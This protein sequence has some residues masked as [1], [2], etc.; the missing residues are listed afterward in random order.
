MIEPVLWLLL[1]LVPV[2][3]VS[4][5]TFRR[6]KVKCQDPSSS[7]ELLLLDSRGRFPHGCDDVGAGKPESYM[8]VE[9]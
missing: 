1:P 4:S 9:Y 8:G 2:D 5:S 7:E 3:H 6:L